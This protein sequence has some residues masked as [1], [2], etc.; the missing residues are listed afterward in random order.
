MLSYNWE[1]EKVRKWEGEQ[2]KKPVGF[3]I[4]N[5]SSK[6]SY[7]WILKNLR[8]LDYLRSK[9]QWYWR[10]AET[11]LCSGFERYNISSRI[12]RHSSEWYRLV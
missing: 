4:S 8:G 7:F 5:S 11:V 1:D 3:L 6:L 2:K 9:H 10:N 12:T